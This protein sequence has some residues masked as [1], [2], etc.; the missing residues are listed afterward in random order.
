[1]GRRALFR[2]SLNPDM[3]PELGLMIDAEN[4]PAL[5]Q[6]CTCVRFSYFLSNALMDGCRGKEPP[7]QGSLC[8]TLS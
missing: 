2:P 3:F 8:E 5:R 6:L 1:M 7:G 4:H